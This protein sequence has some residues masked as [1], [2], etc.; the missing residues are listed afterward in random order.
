[1]TKKATKPLNP[2][3]AK[4]ER[5]LRAWPAGPERDKMRELMKPFGQVVREKR[6]EERREI[7]SWPKER[8]QEIY[9]AILAGEKFGDIAR[10]FGVDLGMVL[11][12]H[13]MNQIKR[14]YYTMNEVSI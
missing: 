5:M 9:A 11:R 13:S 8:R 12:L 1:M 2:T 7:M 4:R 3:A 6:A 10:R 14:F